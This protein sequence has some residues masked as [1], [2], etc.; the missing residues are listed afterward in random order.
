MRR[1]AMRNA[2]APSSMINIRL[3]T[4]RPINAPHRERRGWHFKVSAV[5][6]RPALERIA[7]APA[8]KQQRRRRVPVPPHRALTPLRALGRAPSA[9]D[10]VAAADVVDRRN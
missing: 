10:P 7:V 2:R 6:H 8:V 9:P 3:R 1:A 4:V 5:E